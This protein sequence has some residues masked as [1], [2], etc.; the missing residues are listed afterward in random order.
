MPVFRSMIVPTDGSPFSNAAVA[1]AIRLAADQRASITFVYV[2]ETDKIIASV[3]PGHGY[4]DPTLAINALHE[5]GGAM[6]KECEEKARAANVQATSELPEGDCVPAILDAA[7]AHN[8]D[9]IVMGSHGRGGVT[10][11]LMGSVAEGVLRTTHVP[12]L[13]SRSPAA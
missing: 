10:R 9:L 12:V 3:V 1:L 11:V 4:A 5:A 6:L 7:K 2:V 13:I 8:A